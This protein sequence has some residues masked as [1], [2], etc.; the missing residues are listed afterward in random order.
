MIEKNGEKYWIQKDWL[1]K[2][3]GKYGNCYYEKVEQYKGFSKKKEIYEGIENKKYV[4]MKKSNEMHLV[5]KL[6]NIKEDIS[7][8]YSV[9]K[10]LSSQGVKNLELLDLMM[11]L[12]TQKYYPY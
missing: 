3:F 11:I 5:G 6:R 1:R 9:L 12:V 2:E 8:F 4:L 10:H 7:N